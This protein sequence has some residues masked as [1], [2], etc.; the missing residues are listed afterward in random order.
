M[1]YC[2]W[3]ASGDYVCHRESFEN[4]E[5]RES[6]ESGENREAN[7][8]ARELSDEALSDVAK[9]PPKSIADLANVINKRTADFA[10]SISPST[11][12]DISKLSPKVMSELVN[13]SNRQD[14]SITQTSTALSTA[15]TSYN[16]SRSQMMSNMRNISRTSGV[17]N[18][19]NAAK[20]GLEDLDAQFFTAVSDNDAEMITGLLGPLAGY[21]AY[22]M[23]IQP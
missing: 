6:F 21:N 18:A 22:L 8:M 1:S 13:L 23:N 3:S 9:L 5:N 4:R 17:L 7:Y 14:A 16:N 2:R 15:I 19:F 11:L 10:N 20:K 12:A